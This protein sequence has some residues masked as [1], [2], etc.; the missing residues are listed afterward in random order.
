MEVD[1][2]N[3]GW[4]WKVEPEVAIQAGVWLG[5]KMLKEKH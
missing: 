4:G 1:L 5:E 3:P 2:L